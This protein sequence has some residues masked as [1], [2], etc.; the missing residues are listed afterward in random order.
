MCISLKGFFFFK[1]RPIGEHKIFKCASACG[2]VKHFDFID[3]FVA[4][5][6]INITV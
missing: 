2:N 4:R 6:K 5:Y 3:A 1:A